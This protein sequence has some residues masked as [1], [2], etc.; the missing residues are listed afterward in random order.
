MSAKK[1]YPELS[2]RRTLIS[3]IRWAGLRSPALCD[4]GSCHLS[5][6]CSPLCPVASELA[7]RSPVVRALLLFAAVTCLFGEAPALC[8]LS[9]LVELVVGSVPGP[10]PWL[11]T[12]Y[13]SLQGGLWQVS[14]VCLPP[15]VPCQTYVSPVN[16]RLLLKP[17]LRSWLLCEVHLGSYIGNPEQLT[18][19]AARQPLCLERLVPS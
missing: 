17:P 3:R 1:L 18:V 9:G 8:S 14:D 6:P 2:G 16:C 15:V 12:V 19:P 4:G 11:G 7:V 5:G 10:G 13:S